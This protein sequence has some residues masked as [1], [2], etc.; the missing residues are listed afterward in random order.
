MAELN[1]H[2][3][4]AQHGCDQKSFDSHNKLMCFIKLSGDLACAGPRFCG[5][6]KYPYPHHKGTP[7]P[8]PPP[9]PPLDFPLFQENSRTPHPLRKV[10]FFKKKMLKN[11][12]HKFSACVLLCS[13]KIYCQLSISIN[14]CSKLNR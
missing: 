10:Y 14:I 1:K 11:S 13:V 9:Q 7:T 5:S 2:F 4:F 6:R 8:P 3:L 12:K